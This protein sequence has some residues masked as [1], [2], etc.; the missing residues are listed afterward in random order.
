MSQT[1]PLDWQKLQ[2]DIGAFT[3]VTFPK[4]TARSKALHMSE[5][6]KE[7]ADDPSDILEW[8]DCMILLLDGARKA[9]YSTQDIYA[10]VLRKMEINK[11][12]RWEIP[13]GEGI[14]RHVKTA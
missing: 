5:E 6:A 7:A 13:D 4:A 11:N 2:D 10:G 14:A 8:A 12:R 9:G 1:Y 3:D